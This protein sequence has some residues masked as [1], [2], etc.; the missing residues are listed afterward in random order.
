M[1][2]VL[3]DERGD[4]GLDVVRR[5]GPVAVQDALLGRQ[6]LGPAGRGGERRGLVA[7][8][9]AVGDGLEKHGVDLRLPAPGCRAR[10]EIAFESLLHEGHGGFEVR[11]VEGD[12]FARVAFRGRDVREDERAS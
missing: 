9:D 12:G 2:Q 6:L 3:R 7:G 10:R 8:A 5:D 11:E 4:D 1:Q